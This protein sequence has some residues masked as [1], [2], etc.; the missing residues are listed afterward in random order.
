[1][2]DVDEIAEVTEYEQQYAAAMLAC[3]YR[4]GTGDRK[5]ASGCYSEP[6]CITDEPYGRWEGVLAAPLEP[7]EALADRLDAEA[8]EY[9]QEREMLRRH[10]EFCGPDP[11]NCSCF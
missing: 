4:A 6:A 2:S 3:P 11:D 10:D 9:A 7:A 8:V 5:C 1:M